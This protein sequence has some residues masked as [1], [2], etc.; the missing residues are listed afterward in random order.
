MKARKDARRSRRYMRAYT[1]SERVVASLLGVLLAS[2]GATRHAAPANA[3]EL[4]RL[5]L[6]IQEQPDGTVTHSW[7][8]AQELDLSRFSTGSAAREVSRRIEPVVRRP[9]D[10]DE[11]NRECIRECMSR[12]LPRGFG[13]ITAD[14]QGKGGKE[15]YCRNR[16][17]PPYRDCQELER[18]QPQEF[19]AVDAAVD[20]L[21]RNRRELLVGSVVVIA[22]V[23]FVVAS[24]GAG[25]VILAPAVLLAEATT[26]AEPWMAGGTP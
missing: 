3:G 8:P 14:G 25:L 13:H 16:C 19:A 6:V 15:T 7:Q 2:C 11:E 17:W 20:W 18:L 12:P 24:M 26:G 4:T 21:K 1:A 10:C 9:R 23:V 22:G 5:A